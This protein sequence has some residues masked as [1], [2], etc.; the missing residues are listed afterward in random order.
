MQAAFAADRTS[1]R[2]TTHHHQQQRRQR[3]P[4]QPGARFGIRT[5][6]L[7]EIIPVVSCVCGGLSGY[8]RRRPHPANRDRAPLI[9]R[10]TVPGARLHRLPNSPRTTVPLARP[11]LA[12]DYVFAMRP[13]FK[14]RL[15]AK[16]QARLPPAALPLASPAHRVHL[17]A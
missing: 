13:V 2:R 6:G 7:D 16:A 1:G 9:L 4:A 10:R 14:R 3:L 5:R 17:P 8:S 12:H 15:S 11:F